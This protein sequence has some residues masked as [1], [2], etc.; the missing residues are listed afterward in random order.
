M[1]GSRFLL[2]LHDFIEGKDYAKDIGS[3]DFKFPLIEDNMSNDGEGGRNE[4]GDEE[5]GKY[6][7]LS[8][9]IFDLY[10][11]DIGDYNQT[12]LC[13]VSWFFIDEGDLKDEDLDTSFIFQKRGRVNSF[14]YFCSCPIWWKRQY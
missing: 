12:L 1:D 14:G 2:L 3:D 7:Q 5:D 6:S 9:H 10:D 4:Q 13:G 11:L 8:I